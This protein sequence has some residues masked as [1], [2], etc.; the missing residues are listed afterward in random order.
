VTDDVRVRDV[1]IGDD[2]IRLGQFLKLANVLETGGE[3]KDLI[4]YGEVTVNGEVDTRR[5]RQL[6]RGDVVETLGQSLRV[7]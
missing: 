3:G 1:E 6:F 5:G 4:A 2:M 7:A